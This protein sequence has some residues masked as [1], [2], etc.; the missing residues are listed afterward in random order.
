MSGVT[1]ADAIAELLELASGIDGP[2]MVWRNEV[3][4]GA[5]AAGDAVNFFRSRG[6]VILG[7]DG[8]DTNGRSLFPRL[9][10]IA[11]LSSIDDAVADAAERAADAAL[12]ILA[13]WGPGP[14]FVTFVV[15]A[16]GVHG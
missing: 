11:D 16:H 14:Q 1:R 3:L 4:V 13:K 12:A 9:D 15:R 2:V 8:F 6:D 7:F 5:G 10:Y